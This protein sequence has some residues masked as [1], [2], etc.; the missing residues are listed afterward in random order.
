MKP[1]IALL[2]AVLLM[3]PLYGSDSHKKTYSVT[4]AVV[5]P[6]GTMVPKF[7]VVVRQRSD[8]PQLVRRLHFTDGLF[9]LARLE[10][11]RYQ[12]QISSPTYAG[13][14]LNLKFED[15]K[16]PAAYRVVVLQPI[17]SEPH[18]VTSPY[19]I[20]LKTVGPEV[21]PAAAD[22]YLKGVDLHRLGKL[23]EAM[24]AFGEAIRIY[25]QYVQALSDIGNLYILL[26]RPVSAMSFLQRAHRADPTNL[27]VRLNI[28]TAYV[29]M[30]NYSEGI[31]NFQNILDENEGSGFVRYLLA[32]AYWDQGKLDKAEN[33]IREA[34]KESPGLL[35]GWVLLLNLAGEQG[36]QSCVRET[37]VRLRELVDDTTFSKFVD[38]QITAL[39]LAAIQ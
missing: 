17:R 12:I 1:M 39:K 7:T 19:T 18:V 24:M 31:K 28:A 32:K 4:G 23:D 38:R 37:L 25:P 3:H 21:P 27:V 20:G 34:L 15:G 22:A 9:E 11:G 6:D 30:L 16:N 26:N 8:K 13:V 5:T 35:E 29:N 14:L 36:N 10:G 33:T 2:T